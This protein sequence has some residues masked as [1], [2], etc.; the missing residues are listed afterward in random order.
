MA[1]P[2]AAHPLPL[3]LEAPGALPGSHGPPPP[4]C[5]AV[6]RVIPAGASDPIQSRQ[7]MEFER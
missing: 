5:S 2:T 4:V 6:A 3:G 1:E 7:N